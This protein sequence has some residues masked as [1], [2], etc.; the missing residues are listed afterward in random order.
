MS[1][2]NLGYRTKAVVLFSSEA[3]LNRTF[4]SKLL[5]EQD[6]ITR[7]RRIEDQPRLQINV[8]QIITLKSDL[9]TSRHRPA[10]LSARFSPVYERI[11]EDLRLIPSSHSFILPPQPNLIARMKQ[12]ERVLLDIGRGIL[13]RR[14]HGR[15]KL[16]DAEG[17]ITEGVI[18]ARD[19]F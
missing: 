10:T 13:P 17:R 8:K 19:V 9:G 16:V 15:P 11:G 4:I 6:P 12:P 18:I 7:R 14:R 1:K 3:S 2:T 5:R